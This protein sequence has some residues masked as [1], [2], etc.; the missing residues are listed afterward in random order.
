MQPNYNM[1]CLVRA[2]ELS[3]TTLLFDTSHEISP[4]RSV[5]AL[6]VGSVDLFATLDG[7]NCRIRRWHKTYLRRRARDNGATWRRRVADAQ[8][9]TD[10]LTDSGIQRLTHGLLWARVCA[11][12]CELV[13]DDATAD[14]AGLIQFEGECISAPPV[15]RPA[16]VSDT[17][18]TKWIDRIYMRRSI[19]RARDAAPPPPPSFYSRIVNWHRDPDLSVCRSLARLQRHHAD[20]PEILL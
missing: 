18:P 5:P 15:G 7:L 17:S 12:V 20:V 10:W 16:G 19:T 2:L 11:R 3:Q 13:A 8:R 1:A 14:L 4:S 9:P 6:C